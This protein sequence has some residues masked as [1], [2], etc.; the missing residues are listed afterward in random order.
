MLTG[1]RRLRDGQSETRRDVSFVGFLSLAQL[2]SWGALYYT[3]A[4]VSVPIERDFG[5]DK[6]TVNGAW[7]IGLL[8]TGLAAFPVGICLDR[9]GGRIIMTGGTLLGGACLL[10][11]SSMEHLS[12]L[13]FVCIGLGVAM[14]G[15][16]Y[17]AG[18]AVLTRRFPTSYRDQISRMTL[19]GGLAPT[20]FVPISAWLVSWQGWRSTLLMLAVILFVVCLPIHALG[21]RERST[22][23]KGKIES[24][25][26]AASTAALKRA[27]RHPSFW[28]LLVT[29]SIHSTLASVVVFHIIPLLHERG[30]SDLTIT[31][32]YSLIGPA[33]VGSRVALLATRRYFSMET[34]GIVTVSALP[35]SLALLLALPQVT[36]APASA[37]VLYGTANG[38]ITILRGT[39]IPD[40]IGPEGYGSINGTI[41]LVA[42]I[43][44]AAAPITVAIAWDKF[45]SYGPVVWVLFALAT[46]GALSYGV[47]IYA[48]QG[49][50][51]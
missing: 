8:I 15:S 24:D 30:F 45:G 23:M 40:L 7:S 28:A 48:A 3:F 19:L 14:S 1:L 26:G 39:A 37:L 50:K 27:L 4:V 10:L 20:V 18:F 9:L 11:W 35:V 41:T 21:L 25:A 42:R 6:A 36:I 5:W 44:A 2:I 13:Y 46:I 22:T 38:L 29:F 34:I 12:T 51:A 17:E 43:G 47:A 16:L 31:F 32:A 33:Q 49:R